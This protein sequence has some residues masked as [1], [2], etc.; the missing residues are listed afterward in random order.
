MTSKTSRMLEAER[1]FDGEALEQLIPRLYNSLQSTEKVA[2]E[3]DVTRYTLNIWCMRLGVTLARVATVGASAP[4][5]SI[6]S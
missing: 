1:Q 2:N 6:D 3:L 5:P 4:E